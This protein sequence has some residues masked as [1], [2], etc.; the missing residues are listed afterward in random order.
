MVVLGSRVFI[1]ANILE[2]MG[3]AGLQSSCPFV[4]KARM[5]DSLMTRPNSHGGKSHPSRI[6]LSDLKKFSEQTFFVQT[7]TKYVPL[8]TV[9]NFLFKDQSELFA[10]YNP[11][12]YFYE[13][14]LPTLPLTSMKR[15]GRKFAEFLGQLS[16]KVCSA[17]APTL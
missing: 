9:V 16:V 5:R 6:H 4:Y 12:S 13:L 17:E 15:R 11:L 10:G 7:E 2:R 8:S 3:G 1:L 14:G